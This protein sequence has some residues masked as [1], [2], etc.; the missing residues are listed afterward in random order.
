MNLL[1]NLFDNACSIII[2]ENYNTVLLKYL[3]IQLEIKIQI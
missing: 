3:K 2:H 1:E